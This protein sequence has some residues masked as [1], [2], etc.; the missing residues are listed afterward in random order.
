VDPQI[1]LPGKLFQAEATTTSPADTP[2]SPA[3]SVILLR[4]CVAGPEVH[5]QMRAATMAFARERPVFPGGR[6]DA[7]DYEPV[8]AWAGPSVDEWAAVFGAD[9]D[10]AR[11][12]VCAAIRETFEE[13]GF[14]L[15]SPPDGS[16]LTALDTADW[17][18]DREL[19]SQH[20]LS[21]AQLLARRGLAIRSDWLRA[22]SIWITPE[23][24]PRRFHTWFL[25]ARGPIQQ[26]VLGV[27]SE[28]AASRW[29]TADRALR[30]AD[31]NELRML[32]PQYFTFLQ[33]HRHRDVNSVFGADDPVPTI[34]P[35]MAVDTGGAYLSLPDDLVELGIRTG[36]HMYGMARK[37]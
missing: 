27:C 30:Q 18:A 29:I 8:A 33:L 7:A 32:P 15:A 19:L 13:S 28:K 22:W 16:P 12:V 37:Q 2:P 4:D 23:F 10:Q 17:R 20:Q 24:E 26:R 6:V 34:R 35:A 31:N 9:R 36:H 14:L 3:A 11:A 21:L 5:L 1:R 25:A